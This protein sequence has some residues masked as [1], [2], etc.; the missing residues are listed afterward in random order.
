MF[1]MSLIYSSCIFGELWQFSYLL[2]QL[3]ELI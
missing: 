3:V 1:L 2:I